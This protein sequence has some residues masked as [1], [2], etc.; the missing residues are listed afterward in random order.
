MIIKA[1]FLISYDYEYLKIALPLIYSC[2]DISEIYLAIDQN[3]K[4]WNGEDF[5]LPD[6]FFQWIKDFD[7][8]KKITIYRDNFYVSELSTI[9]CDT[10]ETNAFRTYGKMR[11]VYSNRF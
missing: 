10:R 8:K 1:G 9:D 11:L 7:T 5:T 4:T 2:D 3:F 6:S